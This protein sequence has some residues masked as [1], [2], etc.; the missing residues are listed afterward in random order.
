MIS[1]IDTSVL[2]TFYQ[3]N[4]IKQLN[5]L[6]NEVYIPITVEKQ[7]LKVD[8]DDRLNFLLN[9]YEENKWFKKCQTYQS[10]TIAL[11]G[12][13]RRI[14]EGEREAMAQYKQIQSDLKIE[15]GNIVCV[16][17][18]RI[19]RNVASKMDISL[20]GTLYLLAKLH[21]IG[22]FNYF[23]EIEKIKTERRFSKKLINEAMLK[24]KRDLGIP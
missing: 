8:Q 4:S 15:E 14:H 2:I 18:E 12:T 11:L 19:A 23:E 20:S 9:F 5:L 13:E 7:F 16:I 24:A 10:D 1:I 3:L 6:F 21:L 17:D 22:Y